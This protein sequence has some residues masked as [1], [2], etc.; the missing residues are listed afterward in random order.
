MGLKYASLEA[1]ITA[2]PGPLII[3]CGLDLLNGKQF[4]RIC[5]P[6]VSSR[7]RPVD[8][9]GAVVIADEGKGWPDLL[10]SVADGIEIS[11]AAAERGQ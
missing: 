10:R 1:A 5:R 11:R 8:I 7:S 2:N 3:E 9:L 4:I 6:G